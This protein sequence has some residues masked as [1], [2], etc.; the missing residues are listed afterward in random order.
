LLIFVPEYQI[1]EMKKTLVYSLGLL[2]LSSV[3]FQSCG[4]TETAEPVLVVTSFSDGWDAG[5]Q[6]FTGDI[7][8][9]LEI[10][11]SIDAEGIFNT[12]RISHSDGTTLQEDARTEDGQ[13]TY[14]STFL[15]VLKEAEAGQTITLKVEA[16]DDEPRTVTETVTIITAEKKTPVTKYTAKLLYSPLENLE[17]KTFFSTDDGATYSRNDVEKTADPVSPKIDFGYYYG[18]SDMASIA[19][20][21]AYPTAIYDLS[22]W[23]TKNDTKMKLT[24][25]PASHFEDIENNEDITEHWAMTDMSDADGDVINLAVDNLVAFE[26]VSDKGSKKGFFLVKSIVGTFGTDDYIEI[27]VVVEGEE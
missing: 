27:E 6:T 5:S 22:S 24:E 1:K 16:I 23:G 11:V 12:A 7:G 3:V 18:N 14:K 20:P 10:E 13:T 26:L 4:P 25:M 2:L 15:Y 8:D 17:S 19:S 21:A 9:S